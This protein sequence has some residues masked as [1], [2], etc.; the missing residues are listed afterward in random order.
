MS[1]GSRTSNSRPSAGLKTRSS[2]PNYNDNLSFSVSAG[3]GAPD[4]EIIPETIFTFDSDQY[5]EAKAKAE[6]LLNLNKYKN[7]FIL[8]LDKENGAAREV[9]VNGE[10]VDEYI[11]WL[12]DLPKLPPPN[13]T[14]GRRKR[15]SPLVGGFKI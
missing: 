10:E 7:V 2:H 3:A 5:K 11:T 4:F 9:W 8:A 13:F 15:V 6:A 12:K 14:P 1:R